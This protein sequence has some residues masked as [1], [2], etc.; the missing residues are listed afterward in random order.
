VVGGF[1]S[2]LVEPLFDARRVDAPAYPLG[3]ASGSTFASYRVGVPFDPVELFYS[4]VSVDFFQAQLRS[5]G[6]ELRQRIPAVAALG[7]PEVD[8]V[9]GIARAR[10]EPVHGNWRYYVSLALRP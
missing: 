8:V 6:A 10:D 4:G 5:Y 7:T 9:T 2:P 3:S 1:R